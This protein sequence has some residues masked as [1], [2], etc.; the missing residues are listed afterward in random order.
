MNTTRNG[1]I[2]RLPKII[3]DEL[4]RRL[5]DGERGTQLAVWLNSLPEVQRIIAEQFGGKSLRPQNLSE[6]KQGGY[7]D[8]RNEQ[9]SMDLVRQLPAGAKELKGADG[10]PFSDVLATLL[11]A[12]YA[13]L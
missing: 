10:E 12:R 11:T 7:Q 3:R 5:S 9:Q 8:W 6:W 2:A 4:N 1:K 13:V